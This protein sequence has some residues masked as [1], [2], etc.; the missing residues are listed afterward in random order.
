MTIGEN[1]RKHRKEKGLTQK[2]LGELCIPPIAESTIRRYEL[3][4]LNPKIA[5]IKKIADALGVSV[6]DIYD[7]SDYV[8]KNNGSK[9]IKIFIPHAEL[10]VYVTDEMIKDYKECMECAMRDPAP[11]EELLKQCRDCSWGDIH[12]FDDFVLCEIPALEEKMIELIEGHS[13]D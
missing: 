8:K 1:I 4:K 6:G 7:R 12:L 13:K 3:G 9:V 11:E 2:K 10:R 5:T